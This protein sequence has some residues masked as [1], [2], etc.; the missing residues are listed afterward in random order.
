[1][2]AV[3][4]AEVVHQHRSLNFDHATTVEFINATDTDVTTMWLDSEGQPRAY[5]TFTLGQGSRMLQPTFTGVPCIPCIP[6][7]ADVFRIDCWRPA[8]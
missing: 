8:K 4:S 5:H 7:A 2:G 3:A 1:M 6:C